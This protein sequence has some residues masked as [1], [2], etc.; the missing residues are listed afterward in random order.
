V[1][2]KSLLFTFFCLSS[3]LLSKEYPKSYA[4]LGTPLFSSTQAL[5]KLQNIESL[6]SDIF[7]YKRVAKQT[8]QDGYRADKTQSRVQKKA[9]LKELRMLQKEYDKLLFIL[10]QSIVEAIENNDYQKFERLTSYSFDGLFQSRTLKNRA[11]EFYNQHKA[12]VKSKILEEEINNSQLLSATRKYFEEVVVENS[13]YNSNAKTASTKKVRMQT[14]R[15]KNKIYVSFINDNIY[16]V[17]VGVKAHYENIAPLNG[18][19]NEI[20]LQAHSKVEYTQL[21]ITYS[22]SYYSYNFS[23]IMGSKDAKHNDAYIYRLPYKVGTSHIVSQGYNGQYT[24]KGRSAYSIDFPMPEGTKIYASRGG[25]VV[26]TK[27]NSDVGGYDKKYASSG[28]YV[29]ILH[30]DGTLATYYHLKYRGVLVHAGEQIVKGT[31]LGYSGNTGYSSG[32]HLHFSV[33]QA[34]SASQTQTIPVKI[35]TASGMMVEPKRGVSYESK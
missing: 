16:P 14:K 4:Q 3:T 20:V 30:N 33:F 2:L 1:F 35:L 11:I 15:I 24:H 12:R 5:L 23:W 22:K 27:S 25:V 17:T 31:A 18:T 28:N 8:L 10:H 34:I 13:S 26:K 29:R 21:N 32:P 9:Y 19:K 6:K 7:Q